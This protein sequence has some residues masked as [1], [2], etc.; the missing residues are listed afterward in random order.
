MGVAFILGFAKFAYM[1]ELKYVL[2][3][4][5]HLGNYLTQCF[6]SNRMAI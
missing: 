1:N 3:F 5:I 4:S 2:Y 6:A